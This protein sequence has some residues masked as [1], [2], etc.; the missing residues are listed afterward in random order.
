MQ[1]PQNVAGVT[2]D[3]TDATERECGCLG[4]ELREKCDLARFRSDSVVSTGA[5]AKVAQLPRMSHSQGSL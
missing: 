1:Y 2:S 5:G 4:F 3:K